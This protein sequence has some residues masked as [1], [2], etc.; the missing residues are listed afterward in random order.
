MVYVGVRSVWFRFVYLSRCVTV[1]IHVFVVWS[2][3]G[4]TDAECSST[5]SFRIKPSKPQFGHPYPT[6]DPSSLILDTPIQD[7]TLPA[8]FWSPLRRIWP[9]WLHF[10]YPCPGFDPPNLILDTPIELLKLQAWFCTP[11]SRNPPIPEKVNVNPI[12]LRDWLKRKTY[13]FY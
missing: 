4:T 6:F 13:L 2:R 3:K 1:Y 11:L 10:G 12:F 9:S 8:L 7:L 5:P